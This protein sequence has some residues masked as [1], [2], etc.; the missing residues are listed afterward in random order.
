M[1]SASLALFAMPTPVPMHPECNLPSNTDLARTSDGLEIAVYK[2]GDIVSD[3]IRKTG[4]WETHP[5][6][7]LQPFMSK[8]TTFVDIGANIGWYTVNL[9]RHH[10]VVAF[11]PFKANLDTLAASLCAN[12]SLKQRVKVMPHG[13]S[14]TERRC[15]LY[16]VP[17]VNFGDT[18]S[19]CDGDGSAS[20]ARREA[21]QKNGYQKLGEMRAYPLDKVADQALLQSEKVVKMDVE[22]HEY[23]VILGAEKFFTSGNRPRA[24]YAEVFQLGDKRASFFEK[25]RLWGYETKAGATDND[26]LFVRSDTA[27]VPK[28]DRLMNKEQKARHS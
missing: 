1:L 12:P 20:D 9:A 24:V 8:D 4:S 2:I 7:A 23:E 11:E 26:A 19:A 10:N 15:D 27:A 6:K 14:H 16:Q 3:A 18:V 21:L 28:V 25:M 13:L 22:G 5:W 17:S